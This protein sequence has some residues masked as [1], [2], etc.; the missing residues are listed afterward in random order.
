MEFL[1][2]CVSVQDCLTD[3]ANQGLPSYIIDRINP[4]CGHYLILDGENEGDHAS[5]C[6][7]SFE[8]YTTQKVDGATLEFKCEE[9]QEP[10]T[11]P[12]DEN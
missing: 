4:Q 1:T 10:E 8:C 9:Y 6:I 11:S 3:L 12:T 5:I 7:S 2:A